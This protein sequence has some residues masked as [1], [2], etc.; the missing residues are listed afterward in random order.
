MV[1]EPAAALRRHGGGGGQQRPLH[2]LVEGVMPL[3]E[4]GEGGGQRRRIEGLR[5][6]RRP[7]PRH[8]VPAVRERV[9][10]KQ[11]F[12]GEGPPELNG[13]GFR[14]SAGDILHHTPRVGQSV[15]TL[16][17]VDD[18]HRQKKDV[19]G[20]RQRQSPPAPA[21]RAT[22][23]NARGSALWVTLNRPSTPDGT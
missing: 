21:S 4:T 23:H 20:K 12:G 13:I 22:D 8:R 3:V 11:G 2:R 10:L 5:P 7:H 16:P 18:D 6:H 17:L 15:G 1:G 9:A 19:H 14:Q